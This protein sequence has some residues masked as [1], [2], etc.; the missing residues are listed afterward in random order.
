MG[1]N[2]S[3][4]GNRKVSFELDEQERVRVLRGIRL[5][6]DVVNRMK[7]PQLSKRDQQSPSFSSPSSPQVSDGKS[8]MS[9]GIHPPT[10]DSLGRR[11]S[12]AEEDL[13]KRYEQEQAMVQEELLRLAKRERDAARERLNTTLQQERISTDEERQKTA[14]LSQE[15]QHKEEELKQRDA[16]YKE[17]LARI[18]QKNA[19]IYKLTLEQYHE[20][21]TNA[22]DQ[23]RR[24]NTQP[25]CANLQADIMKCY[26]ENKHQVLNCSELV[27]EYRRCVSLA[28]KELLVHFD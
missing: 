4:Q 18:E 9:T 25:V 3:S 1:G 12:E 14:Q 27:K 19:D 13:Y 21:V 23:V 10:V 2:E 6:E 22:E 28:Q 26:S 15:L 17:Q 24:R 20:A 5:S 16:F 8:K 11:P 7:E